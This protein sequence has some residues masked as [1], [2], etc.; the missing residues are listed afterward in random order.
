MRTKD[1]SQS[2]KAKNAFT[3]VSDISVW[4]VAG[5]SAPHLIPKTSKVNKRLLHSFLV[6]T[7]TQLIAPMDLR[8]YLALQSAFVQALQVTVR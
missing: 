5:I 6:L 8:L 7:L 4:M 2:H 3:E 1:F